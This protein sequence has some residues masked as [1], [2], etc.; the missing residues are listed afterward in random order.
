MLIALALFGALV[1]VDL[2]LFGWLIFRSL[3]QRE[4]NRI[5]LE[6]RAEAEELAGRLAEEA[7]KWGDD[8]YT[9]VAT[10]AETRTYI[11]Q[12]L[13]KREIVEVVRVLDK[14]QR[15]VFEGARIESEGED[16]ELS[17][18]DVELPSVVA[19]T[20]R[21]DTPFETVEVPVGHVGTFVIGLRR[22]EIE[23]RLEVLRRDLIRQ[24][25]LISVLSLVLLGSAYGFILL[26]MRRAGRAEE[27]VQEAE[28]LAY[29]GTLA[30]GLAHEIR[31]PLNSLNLNMQ[32]LE[33]ELHGG[34]PAAPIE[35]GAGSRRLLQITRAEIS[36]LE[37]L[38]SDFLSYARPRGL[39]LEELPARELLDRVHDV[40]RG[41]AALQ[42]LRLEV[43]DNTGGARVRVDREQI[44]QLLLN[45]TENAVQATQEGERPPHVRLVAERRQDR[46]AL[47]VVDNGVGMTEEQRRR[48]TE[49]FF[50]LRKG[51]TG[52][53]LAIVDRIARSH[54]G[55]LAIES[56]P[57]EGTRVE[58]LL[59]A[60]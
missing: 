41:R 12:V 24:A 10:N 9:A 38:V 49:V 19:E 45:L 25:G 51:G 50:S 22:A 31:S 6:T 1:A 43:Q 2:G 27:Q 18:G 29:V 60:A 32:M 53:G 8:L 34:G 4:I 59:P 20:F 56:E 21:R 35:R 40:Y 13:T 28:R 44:H 23:E 52:L 33:E 5:I 26:L 3:S 55:S 42:G 7:E 48:A 11:D 47:A 16:F 37:R 30:S 36:R 39:E 17:P 14:E 58:V 46:V 57:G 15:V 54:D